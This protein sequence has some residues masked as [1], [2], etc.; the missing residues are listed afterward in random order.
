MAKALI[1][2]VRVLHLELSIQEAS[3]LKAVMQNPLA[4][5]ESG[6][7]ADMRKELFEQLDYAFR[8]QP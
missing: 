5:G 3:W 7:G 1:E 4:H 6:E 2:T 8:T